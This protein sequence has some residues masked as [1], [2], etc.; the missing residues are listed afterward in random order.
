MTYDYLWHLKGKYIMKGSSFQISI[1]PKCY[2]CYFVSLGKAAFK[3]GGTCYSQFKK[4]LFLL[5]QSDS[6][7]TVTVGKLRLMVVTL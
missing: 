4:Y 6:V 5:S 7:L 1:Y 2:C 3:K